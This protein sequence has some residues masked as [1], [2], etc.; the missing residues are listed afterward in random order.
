[1]IVKLG[2]EKAKAEILSNLQ[3]CT[4]AYGDSGHTGLCRA[5]RLKNV[6]K[7]K[8]LNKIGKNEENSQ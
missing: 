6:A 5:A 7:L 1:M 4:C 2:N 3:R 8:Q